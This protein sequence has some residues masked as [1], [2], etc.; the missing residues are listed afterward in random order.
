MA[1]SR[2]PLALRRHLKGCGGCAEFATELRRQRRLIAIALPVAVCPGLKGSVFAAVGAGGQAGVGKGGLVAGL[3]TK[4]ALISGGGVGSGGAVGG[5]LTA[6][7][8]TNAGLA[9]AV[10]AGLAV[11]TLA[12]SGVV[13]EKPAPD[14]NRGDSS[15]ASERPRAAPGKRAFS[16]HAAVPRDD[17]A[18]AAQPLH[19][20]SRPE[21]SA[22]AAGP[23]A[24]NDPSSG[25]EVPAGQ[26]TSRPAISPRQGAG[27]APQAGEPPSGVVPGGQ[28]STS[29]RAE[30]RSPGHGAGG[31]SQRGE[32]NS[33]AR[34]PE[35]GRRVSGR[36]RQA[37]SGP[38]GR[39]P[40]DLARAPARASDEMRECLA[41]FHDD[42]RRELHC[43]KTLR[44]GGSELAGAPPE[45][46]PSSR[47]GPGR[48]E[49]PGRP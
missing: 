29:R 38:S 18:R 40:T 30:R 31:G 13:M 42:P 27:A 49:Q 47:P 48:H 2:L 45:Q 44:A 33:P 15:S 16:V 28:R 19:S 17:P 7:L 26:I 25:A 46:R 9:T 35:G 24:S 32:P 11:V 20:Q 23:A 21:P 36:Q 4:G 10:G 6:A 5:G 43:A 1:Q 22:S 37:A 8:A 12:G 39:H 34:D 3:A 41:T 14:R